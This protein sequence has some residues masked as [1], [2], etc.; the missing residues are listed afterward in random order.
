M[1]LSRE[2]WT[3]A[4]LRALGEE[5]FGGVAVEPLARRLGATKGSFYWHFKDRDELLAATLQRWEDEETSAV[6]ELVSG[7]P[8]PR[9]RLLALAD[10]ALGDALRGGFDA[11]ILASAGDPRVEPVLVRV[12]KRR[13]AYIAQLYRDLGLG[14]KEAAQHAR[15]TYSLF[16][17][18]NQ[19][20]R[21]EGGRKP[22]PAEV[23]RSVEL[24]VRGLL[25]SAGL[26]A[27]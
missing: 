26:P 6:I 8:D 9:E 1:A 23:K 21:A 7:I 13:M 5:G 11:T 15:V 18:M 4:A 3:G 19:L 14:R 22:G 27:E 2:E 12:T 20:S 16:L 10:R 24:A 17:G 25:L